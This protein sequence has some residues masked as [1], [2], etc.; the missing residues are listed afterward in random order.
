MPLSK[1][2]PDVQRRPLTRGAVFYSDA[3]EKG[4]M[5]FKAPAKE[6]GDAV[7]GPCEGGLHLKAPAKGACT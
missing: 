5:H 2:A 1:G 7:E 6:G 4:A 3:P